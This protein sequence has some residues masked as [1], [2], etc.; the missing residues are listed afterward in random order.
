MGAK[1][2]ELAA[3]GIFWDAPMVPGY[4]H[5]HLYLLP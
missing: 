4:S 3:Y 2:M 1:D 5:L